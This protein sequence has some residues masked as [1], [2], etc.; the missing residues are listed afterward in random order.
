MSWLEVD[1]VSVAYGLIRALDGV[2]LAVGEGEIVA[3]VGSNCAGKSTLMKA[4]MG[5]VRPRAG[6]IAFAGASLLG[7]AVEDVVRLGVVLVPEARGVLRHLSV[8]ENLYL[9]AYS[10]RDR[11]VEGD[12]DRVATRFP[13]LAS[14]LGQKAGTLSG[15]EQQMLA[16]GR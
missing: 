9:G 4:V 14:R 6:A 16:L 15:G 2:S 8:R 10:R 11:E 1:D 7:I 13:S 3:L 5:V 12:L